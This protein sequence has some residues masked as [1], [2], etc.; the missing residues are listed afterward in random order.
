MPEQTVEFT[1]A[2]PARAPDLVLAEGPG[3]TWT[4][5]G[6]SAPLADLTGVTASG[7]VGQS[8]GPAF[9][10][11]VPPLPELAGEALRSEQP[12]RGVLV[13]FPSA[14]GRTLAADVYAG[15]LTADYRWRTVAFVFREPHHRETVA[16]GHGLVGA[17]PALHQLLRKIELY[18][19]TD[20]AVVITGETGTGKELVAKA[21]H[22]ASARRRGPYVAVNC[23]A[24]SDEL[25]ESELFGHEKGAFT[26]AVRSHRG[27]FERADGGT[28]FL[29]E[30]GDMPLHTQAKLLRALEG[31]RIERVGAET[32]KR[33]DV[34]VLAATNVPLEQAVGSGRFRADLYHRLSVLRIHLPPLRERPEDI[35]PLVEHFL[36]QFSGKYGRLIHRLTPEALSLLQSYLWPGNVRE[37]RN[38]L[39]R[40]FIE[41]EAQVIGARAFGEW[42]RERQSFAPGD[43]GQ[44]A[45]RGRPSV[46]T[47][48]YPLP[49]QQQLLAAAPSSFL[50]AELLPARRQ[51]ST[52]PV[53]LGTEEVSRA[54]REAGGNIA[55][56]ARLLGVHRATL[57]RHLKKLGLEREQLDQQES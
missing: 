49:S 21:L 53:A 25:L 54:Y 34:R 35:P 12:L 42:I 55:G 19:P 57:Y 27:R 46:M 37:L 15:G 6:I 3:G 26:G 24:I 40:V 23:S 56:A 18:G 50:E 22:Q 39:E 11:I 47:P 31:G 7:M 17:S 43:W 33:V 41:T 30:I 48:P 1:S 45:G 10:G 14:G 32:E 51:P 16:T 13:R 52:R 5:L 2:L 38:V 36:Q 4:V 8:V 29:D 28:L 44:H 9:S 20:A